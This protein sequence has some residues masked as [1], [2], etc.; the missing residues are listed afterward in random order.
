MTY[1]LL[2]PIIFLNY[3]KVL[4]R[5][6]RVSQKNHFLLSY[7]NFPLLKKYISRDFI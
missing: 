6:A 3:Y 7:H 5:N 1:N 4:R 2:Y